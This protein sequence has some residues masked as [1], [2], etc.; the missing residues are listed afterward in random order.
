MREASTLELGSY[1][2]VSWAIPFSGNVSSPYQKEFRLL[3]DGSLG[4]DPSTVKYTYSMILLVNPT[5]RNQDL[6][7][8]GTRFKKMFIAVS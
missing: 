8:P 3:P 7:P 5:I 2:H 1:L 6:D 4:V